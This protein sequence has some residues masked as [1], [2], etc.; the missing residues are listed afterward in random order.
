MDAAASGVKRAAHP[1]FPSG[2][3][4]LLGKWYRTGQ[5]KM[6]RWPTVSR[7]AKHAERFSQSSLTEILE[8]QFMATYRIT[9]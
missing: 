5:L 9:K 2:D 8:Y 3:C 4:L 6:L 1:P 7:D